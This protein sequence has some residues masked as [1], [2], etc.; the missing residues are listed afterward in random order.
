M[1]R[2]KAINN[3]G[4]QTNFKSKILPFYQIYVA[5]NGRV[6]NV[7]KNSCVF[8]SKKI[9]ISVNFVFLNQ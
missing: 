1:E 3:S 4:A 9:I 2:N 5:N 6:N 7:F 8:R